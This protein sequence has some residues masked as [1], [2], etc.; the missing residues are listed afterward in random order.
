MNERE[1]QLFIYFLEAAAGKLPVRLFLV[2]D[3]RCR[4]DAQKEAAAEFAVSY[5]YE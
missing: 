5:M 4:Y 2:G 1:A 3:T